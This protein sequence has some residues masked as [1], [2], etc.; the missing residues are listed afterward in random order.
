MRE[1]LGQYAWLVEWLG[2][3]AVVSFIA[4]LILVPLAMV[5][6]PQDY[7]VRHKRD[8]MRKHRAH[9]LVFGTAVLAK[10]LLGVLLILAGLVM[11]VL[12]GQGLLTLLIGLML[13]NFPGKYHL[14]QAL[15]RQRGISGAI[16]ALRVRA[17]KPEL[18]LPDDDH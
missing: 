2:V 1:W 13:T 12:P 15:I 16:N 10:N 3:I 8:P 7:F 5:Q 11:L 17:G 6:L 4:T 9:P 14:E 18:I